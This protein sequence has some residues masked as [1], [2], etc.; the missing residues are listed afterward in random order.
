[1]YRIGKAVRESRIT[2]AA[3]PAPVLVIGNFTAGGTGKTPLTI[4]VA[5]WL[6]A[7][8]RAPAILSRGHGRTSRGPVQVDAD[9]LVAEGGDEPTLLFEQAGVPVFVDTDRVAAGRAALAAG[10]RVLLCDDGLQHRAL[11]RDIE[12][13]VVDGVRGYGNFLLLPAGPLR[14]APRACDLR[15]VNG[16]AAPGVARP[17]DW[18]MQLQAGAVRPLDG[19]APSRR[20]EDFAGRT[21]HAVAGIGNPARFFDML[22]AHGLE[23][24]P[25]AFGDHHAYSPVEFEN[26]GRPLLMTAKDAVKCRAYGLEDAWVVDVEAVLD[27]P[28]FAA[29]ARA[30]DAIDA[31]GR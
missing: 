22:R 29:L 23:V 3:L 14:E 19:A 30:L 27:P 5:R 8:G 1:L 25:H 6:A 9:T 31:A 2:P 7:E 28:F 13:E 18:T 26:V 24:V 17:G 4:A 16:P 10:A 21:V 15:V 11:A 12:I 20:L